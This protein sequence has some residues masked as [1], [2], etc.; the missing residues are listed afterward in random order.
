MLI[1]GENDRQQH[2]SPYLP[3]CYHTFTYTAYHIY[4]TQSPIP[5]ITGL[6]PSASE[7]LARPNHPTPGRPWLPFDAAQLDSYFRTRRDSHDFTTAIGGRVFSDI[8]LRI[9]RVCECAN[10]DHI[11]SDS[12]F[13]ASTADAETT[14]RDAAGTMQSGVGSQRCLLSDD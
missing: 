9:T 10:R 14:H 2:K 11:N 5:P 13:S 12:L 8:L 6:I 1:T 3:L 7:R 4:N